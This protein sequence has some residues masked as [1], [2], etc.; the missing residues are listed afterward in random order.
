MH[1]SSSS[2]ITAVCVHSVSQASSVQGSPSSHAFIT[3]P[4]A[5]AWHASST[6]Q[7]SPSSHAAP[8][9]ASFATQAPLSDAHTVNEHA[10]SPLVSQVTTVAGSTLHSPASQVTTPLHRSPSSKSAQSPSVSHGQVTGVPA[11]APDAQASEAVHGLPS[12]HGVPASTSA[13]T[14]AP[15]AGSQLVTA[16]SVSVVVSQTTTESGS[17]SQAPS[18]QRSEPLHRSASSRSA[19]SASDSHT[20][21][22][23]SV[24]AQAPSE[25]ESSVVQPLPSSH[26][27]ALAVKTQP[28]PVGSQPSSVH[29]SP[30]SQARA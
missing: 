2:H 3:P 29:G 1:A 27:A 5:P 4:Q 21:S 24:P 19:Q 18:L 6:V 15:L 22:S 12:E 8:W 20:H 11:Q 16:H 14:H 28:P 17:I 25:Q 10:V 23:V 26:G 7:A 13:W 9:T 30:S